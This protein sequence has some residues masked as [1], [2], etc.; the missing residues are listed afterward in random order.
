[1]HKSERKSRSVTSTDLLQLL[2]IGLKLTGHLDGWS[3]WQVMIPTIVM[4]SIAIID[5]IIMGTSN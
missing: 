1:M 5:S 3:W 4:I 2:F